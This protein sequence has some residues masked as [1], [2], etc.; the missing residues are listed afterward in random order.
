MK[1]KKEL[2]KSLE[3]SLLSKIFILFVAMLVPFKVVASPTIT[4]EVLTST[5]AKYVTDRLTLEKIGLEPL[6]S[7]VWCYNDEANSVLITAP[8]R[9][10]EQCDLKLSQELER[11]NLRHKLQVDTLQIEVDTLRSRHNEV[12]A[13]KNEQIKELTTAALERPNDYSLWWATG[14]AALGVATTLIIMVLVK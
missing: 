13:L 3:S 2:K 1:L 11:V 9:E 6:S 7:P 10:R 12:L 5:S 4:G 14:G 8:S